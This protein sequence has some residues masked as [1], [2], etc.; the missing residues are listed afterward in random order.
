MREFVEK[1]VVNE[2]SKPWRKK[3]YTQQV[4]VYFNFVGRV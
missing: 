2:R 1:I 3:N 4:Y